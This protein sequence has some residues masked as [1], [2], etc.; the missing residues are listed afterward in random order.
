VYLPAPE[1]P[2]RMRE[3]GSRPPADGG[4]ERFDGGGVADEVV[5]VGGRVGAVVMACIG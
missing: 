1:G 4:T 5:E 2:A 3:W